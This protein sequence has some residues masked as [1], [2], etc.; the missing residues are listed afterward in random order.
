[1]KKIDIDET[2]KIQME[3][4]NV[5]IQFC[6]NNNLSY[7]L[8]AGSL[9][10]AVRHSGYI[11][12]DDDI[13][14]CMPRS[15]YEKFIQLA[16]NGL[17]K[18]IE[19]LEPKD[20]I[21]PM[22]KIINTKTRLVEFP[23]TIKNNIS[24]YIDVFPKD[25]LPDSNLIANVLCG[26]CRVLIL[27]NWFNKV[28]IFKWQDEKKWY[29]RILASIGRKLVNEKNRNRPL[30]YLD[31]FAKLYSYDKA[32]RVSTIVA[33]GMKNCIERRCFDSYIEMSFEYLN[34]KIPYGHHEYLLKLYGDYMIIPPEKERITHNNIAYM[35]DEYEKVR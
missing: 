28:S 16:R 10:G 25:G 19:L 17:T 30:T 35:I 2:R 6:K 11:P 26:V 34:V 13:D 29:K 18:N 1:M 12:W 3:I 27:W 32:I 14:V 4:L 8:D 22:L 31:R 9:L 24:V 20:N 7:F 5:F 21:Y 33:G 23:N 15:D